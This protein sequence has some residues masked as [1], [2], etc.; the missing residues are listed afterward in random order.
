MYIRNTWV[1]VNAVTWFLLLLG[2]GWRIRNPNLVILQ[3]DLYSFLVSYDSGFVFILTRFGLQ[4][5]C[6]SSCAN[7]DGPYE[8]NCSQIYWWKGSKEATRHQG[9]LFSSFFLYFAF[10]S[11]VHFPPSVSL[12]FICDSSVVIF[13]TFYLF[14]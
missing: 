14:F 8:A 13:F 4:I 3:F 5:I 2:G 6:L 11:Y 1:S 12:L 10:K 9:F 7:Q